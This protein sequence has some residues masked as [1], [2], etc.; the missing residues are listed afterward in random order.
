M[1]RNTLKTELRKFFVA[2]Q[3]GSAT[4][5]KHAECDYCDARIGQVMQLI[6]RYTASL[7]YT[8]GPEL[9][10]AEQA[11]DYLG[12]SSA[13]AARSTLSRAGIEAYGHQLVPGN[14]RP[15]A[16][17]KADDVKQLADGRLPR[18]REKG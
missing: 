14:T 10:T 17:Y 13:A 6:D 7:K 11:A 16:M 1:D 5:F 3:G 8:E 2:H 18:Q 12:L 15:C 9:W 4:S